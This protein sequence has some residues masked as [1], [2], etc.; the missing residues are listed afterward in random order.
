[1]SSLWKFG[2][3]GLG[4]I[5]T[6]LDTLEEYNRLGLKTCEIAFT[7]S[8]YIKN[9]GDAEKIGKR[10]EELGIE[11]RI[12]GPYWVNLNSEEPQKIENSKNLIL[13]CLEVGT[14]LGA[15]IVVFH[16]GF[17][18]KRSKEETYEK[19]K[20]GILEIENERKK[21]GYTTEMAPETM[22]KINVFGST[23]EIRK[24]VE[25][26]GC[27]FCIDFAHILARDKD[28][29]FEEVLKLFEKFEKLYL[30]FSGI[31]YGEKGEKHHRRTEED[32]WKKFLKA[33][34]KNKE[35]SIVNE[36][37]TPVEDAIEGLSLSRI[38]GI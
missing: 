30:H 32:E 33:L 8:V 38:N 24:L 10:A 2:P 11:L 25:D 28:Y 35:I 26:T 36:S 12:H 22:G 21:R 37:P 23:G 6:A 3:S 18:G 20:K 15:K 31:V 5:K 4:P 27:N 13:R 16:P 19:I 17:Y 9:K 34:P 1:M 7:Y 29:R 14:W